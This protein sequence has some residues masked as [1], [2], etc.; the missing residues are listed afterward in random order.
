MGC[1]LDLWLEPAPGCAVPDNCFAVLKNPN[2]EACSPVL[3]CAADKVNYLGPGNEGDT[4][5]VDIF[6]RVGSVKVNC[7][8]PGL[9]EEACIDWPGR[10]ALQ[11]RIKVVTV[12]L[13]CKTEETVLTEVQQPNETELQRDGDEGFLSVPETGEPKLAEVATQDQDPVK[14]VQL[15]RASTES[16]QMP[17]QAPLPEWRASE[18]LHQRSRTPAAIA[19]ERAVTLP[20]CDRIIPNLYLGGVNAASDTA[21][22]C[23]AGIRAVCCCCRE[24]EFPSKEFS[25]QLEYYRVDVEDM[26]IEPIELFFGEATEFIHSWVS[27]EQPVLVHCRAGVSRSASVVIAY[28]IAFHGYSL[29]DAFFLVRSRRSVVTPNLGFMEKL[30]DFEESKRNTDPTI[31]INKYMAW[32]QSPDRA[33]VPDLQPD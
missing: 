14:P 10:P 16:A 13:T 20:H 28:L 27:R 7:L 17:Q 8:T 18:T 30:G 29:H 24:M 31:D 12:D 6:Q 26:S 19:L 22:L 33:G 9:L 3:P 32:Y 2:S 4:V 23:D 25:K 1:D 11:L 5:F 15:V 21:S